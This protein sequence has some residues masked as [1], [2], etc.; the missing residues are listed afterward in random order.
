M[1]YARPFWKN[2]SSV[3]NLLSNINSDL[4]NFVNNNNNNNQQQNEPSPDLYDYND[5]YNKAIIE[6]KHELRYIDD[7][8]KLENFYR[9]NYFV[10]GFKYYYAL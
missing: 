8:T 7:T 4:N 2:N 10:K 6:R 3:N 1:V 9:S 5:G